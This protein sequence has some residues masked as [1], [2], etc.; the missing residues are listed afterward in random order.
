MS[1]ET[2][3]IPCRSDNYA[4]LLRDGVKGETAVVDVPE[5]A[6]I[7]AALRQRDWGLDLIL[8]THHHADHVDGTE[9]V[10]KATGAKVLGARAD[11]HRLPPLA[12]ALAP[13]D[14]VAL[15]GSVAEVL[16]VSGH[17]V[18]HIAFH[19]AA[20]AAVFTADSLMALGCGRI[21]EGTPEMMWKSLSRLAALP[22]ETRVYSGHEY[23]Q[24][25]ARFA[26]TVEPGNGALEARAARI[27]ALRA[28]GEPTVPASL[29]EEL[30][31]N[32]FLRA[33]RPEVKQALGMPGATDV[34]V[35]AEIR[36]RKDRF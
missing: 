26:L 13:G 34:Q 24:T 5:A 7:L 27:D 28:R 25:N 15:G 33:A 9:E 11:A 3:T 22:P 12:R 19:F 14:R 20:D 10:R 1:L 16:D 35:F 31:T 23:T 18:G 29:R 6:P 21:F 30:D 2:V 4:Y 17:T 32:P 36:A 8:I